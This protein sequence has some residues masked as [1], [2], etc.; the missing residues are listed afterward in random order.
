MNRGLLL[1]VGAAGISGVSVLV[2][3]YGVKAFGDATT[4][5]T[6]KNTVAAVAPAVDVAALLVAAV[7]ITAMLQA[8]VQHTA[9]RPDGPGSVLAGCALVSVTMI[10]RHRVQVSA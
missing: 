8:V 4:Y 10:S 3:S 2:N 1:A 5:T 6:A 7:P 9:L